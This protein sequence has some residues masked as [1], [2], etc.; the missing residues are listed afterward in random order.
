MSND[1]I[2]SIAL[3]TGPGITLKDIVEAEKPDVFLG[4]Y[5]YINGIDDQRFRDLKSS[6][7]MSPDISEKQGGANGLRWGL[8]MAKVTES[9]N[10]IAFSG[11]ACLRTDVPYLF[12]ASDTDYSSLKKFYNNLICESNN[13]CKV[14]ENGLKKIPKLIIDIPYTSAFSLDEEQMNRNM[15]LKFNPSEFIYEKDGVY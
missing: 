8:T 11:N 14:T 7:W 2:W 13:D 15:R 10:D 12:V 6:K 3:E 9:S 4:S 1:F 5:L